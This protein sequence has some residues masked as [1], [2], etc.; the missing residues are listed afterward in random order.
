MKKNP[1]LLH[2]VVRNKIFALIAFLCISGNLFSKNESLSSN[3]LIFN[4]YNNQQGESLSLNLKGV[5]VAA[6]FG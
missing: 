4:S 6:L 3:Y 5:N 1:S 2:S